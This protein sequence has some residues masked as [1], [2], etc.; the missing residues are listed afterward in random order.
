MQQGTQPSPARAR[1][2]RH[3]FTSG[4][5]RGADRR[6]V[7]ASDR[8][9]PGN[10]FVVAGL[11]LLVLVLVVLT[12]PQWGPDTTSGADL[13]ILL[14]QLESAGFAVALV[15]TV[16][17]L[18]RWRLVGEAA[19]VWLGSATAVF[20]VFTLGLGYVLALSVATG[21]TSLLLLH[22]ASGLVVAGLALRALLSSDVDAHLRPSGV[23]LASLGAVATVTFAMQFLPFSRQLVDPSPALAVVHTISEP[24]TSMAFVV[25]WGV[26]GTWCMGRGLRRHRPLFAWF[27]LLFFAFAFAELAWL[28]PTP[29]RS[30]WSLGPS[31]LRFAGLFCALMGATAELVRAYLRQGNLLLESVTSERTAEARIEAELA[32]QAERAH[33]ARNALVAIE[34]AILTLERHRDRLDPDTREEL[35]RSVSSEVHR[36]QELVQTAGS[37][38]PSGR[39]R[40][41]EALA[42]TVTCARS[43]GTSLHVDVPEHL[44]AIGQPAATS[45]V[46]LNLFENVRRYAGGEATVRASLEGDEVVIRVEDDGPGISEAERSEIFRR[47]TRGR[48]AGDV[49]GS[50]LGLYVSARLM[51]DQGGELRVEDSTRGGACFAVVLPGFSELPLDATV[52]EELVDELEQPLELV[53]G[54]QGAVVALPVDGERRARLVERDGGLRGRVGG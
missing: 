22:P 9:S 28:M 51:R 25:V 46:L 27:G 49:P 34:G 32:T 4:R 29:E 6:G 43:Q 5:Y 33:E 10:T 21:N 17:C 11:F 23:L 13:G 26:L 18:V 52:V 48:T 45:Q 12:G 15:L 40:V 41:T 37:P 30:F 44:V 50:G 47:G 35:S 53:R 3:R 14:A 31:M 54:G 42:A 8:V 39:F 19:A 1:S 38:Q 24:V 7:I 36:L 16:L 2:R 20:G